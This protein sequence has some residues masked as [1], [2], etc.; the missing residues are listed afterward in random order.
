MKFTG[1]FKPKPVAP[2]A[3][4]TWL[5]R[6]ALVEIH[7]MLLETEIVDDKGKPLPEMRISFGQMLNFRRHHPGS[8]D[9]A[10]VNSVFDQLK[11]DLDQL[12]K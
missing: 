2:P 11:K 3:D 6:A 7:K 8:W 5:K 10:R 1:F 9:D 4:K 12:K